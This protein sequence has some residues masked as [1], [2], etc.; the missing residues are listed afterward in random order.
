MAGPSAVK[1]NQRASAEVK[2]NTFPLRSDRFL[3]QNHR[4]LQ[5]GSGGI[6]VFNKGAKPFPAKKRWANFMSVGEGVLAVVRRGRGRDYP[7]WI[8]PPRR[9]AYIA[10][11]RASGDQGR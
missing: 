5:N 8:H 11:K 3:I 4:Q 2:G 10:S 1:E 7:K 9:R 6:K